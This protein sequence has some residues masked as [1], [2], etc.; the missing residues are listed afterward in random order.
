MAIRK[1]ALSIFKFFNWI[2]IKSTHIKNVLLNL[3]LQTEHSH[4]TST[5]IKKQNSISSLDLPS[6]LHASP[7]QPKSLS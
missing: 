4:M 6:S 2:K 3:S 7:T 1:L 5:Q